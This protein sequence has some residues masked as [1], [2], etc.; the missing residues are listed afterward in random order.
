M[1]KSVHKIKPKT[2]IAAEFCTLVLYVLQ[3]CLEFITLYGIAELEPYLKI[4]F[5]ESS[6]LES[7]KQ[8]SRLLE[9][10]SMSRLVADPEFAQFVRQKSFSSVSALRKLEKEVETEMFNARIEE[11]LNYWKLAAANSMIIFSSEDIE[12]LVQCLMG[13]FKFVIP[14]HI[15][16]M[17]TNTKL[18]F[19]G[20]PLQ[21]MIVNNIIKYNW[22]SYYTGER[23]K[24]L[25][26]LLPVTNF[27]ENLLKKLELLLDCLAPANLKP[28]MQAIESRYY[29]LEADNLDLNQL[30]P[31]TYLLGLAL[32]TVKRTNA[33]LDYSKTFKL[34]LDN[35]IWH[36]LNESD[37]EETD[38]QGKMNLDLLDVLY[39]H[40]IFSC[41]EVYYSLDPHLI[42]LV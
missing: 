17:Q 28:F 27:D 3:H 26:Q 36:V 13:V 34:L 2:R 22:E 37:I 29:G 10:L 24:F 18:N 38:R 12:S 35:E 15:A 23:S 7:L 20:K 5:Y 42:Q 41:Y 1:S 31:L 25:A 19:G 33:N 4:F 16:I 8:P 9:L 32:D 6:V 30:L 39:S 14:N 11:V 40:A 21:E